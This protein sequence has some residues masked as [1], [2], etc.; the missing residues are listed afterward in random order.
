MSTCKWHT[1]CRW[2][3]LTLSRPSST[4]GLSL[5]KSAVR[6]I[7]TVASIYLQFNSRL[8]PRRVR[9]TLTPCHTQRRYL[10]DVLIPVVSVANVSKIDPVR[11]EPSGGNRI[12]GCSIAAQTCCTTPQPSPGSTLS[13]FFGP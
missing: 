9:C 10:T 3:P 11:C 13:V 6:G 4:L 12:A 5:D 1:G 7:R 2:Y 8:N